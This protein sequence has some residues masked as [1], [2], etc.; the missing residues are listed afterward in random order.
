MSVPK[1]IV[2]HDQSVNSYGLVVLTNPRTDLDPR[3]TGIDLTRFNDNPVMLHLHNDELLLGSWSDI[4]IETD[5]KITGAPA[6]NEDNDYAADRKQEYEAGYLKGASMSFDSAV[7]G[8]SWIDDVVVDSR[9]GFGDTPVLIRS[10]VNECTLCPIPSNASALQMKLDGKLLGPTEIK[11]ELKLKLSANNP[12]Q[13]NLHIML[14]LKLVKKALNLDSAHDDNDTLGEVLSIIKDH[15]KITKEL[16]SLKLSIKADKESEIKDF[17]DEAQT[18][19]KFTAEERP[20][21]VD[22]AKLNLKATKKLLGLTKAAPATQTQHPVKK[23]LANAG[24]AGG[25]GNAGNIELTKATYDKM[26]KDGTLL[27]LKKNDIETYEALLKAKKEE[28]TA[29]GIVRTK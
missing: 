3:Y 20:E 27:L 13:N 10:S 4:K 24:G 17:L 23:I 21:Y 25:G 6:F 5:G 18:A 15:A 26:H 8:E 9:L 16:D 7:P 28:V 11:Q 19:G 12:S 1:R 2:M 14:D 29:S 22:M